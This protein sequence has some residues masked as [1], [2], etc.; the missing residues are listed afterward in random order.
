MKEKQYVW[1]CGR[2][3]GRWLFRCQGRRYQITKGSGGWEI[4]IHDYDVGDYVL[5]SGQTP[6]GVFKTLKAARRALQE[7]VDKHPVPKLT[8]SAP[9]SPS[10]WGHE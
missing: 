8:I 6:E 1:C 9:S 4:G 10:A 7:F 2:T 5:S 3:Q